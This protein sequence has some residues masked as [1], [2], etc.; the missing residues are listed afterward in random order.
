[1]KISVELFITNFC[2]RCASARDTLAATIETVGNNQIEV[3]MVDVVQEIDHAVVVGVRAIPA[4]AIDGE[5]VW[6]GGIDGNLRST[7]IDNLNTRL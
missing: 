2:P 5:L 6:T 1:M 7:L 4:V 3:K